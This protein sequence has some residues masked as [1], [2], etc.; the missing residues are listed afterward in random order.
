MKT[1]IGV[2]VS[3]LHGQVAKYGF[4]LPPD[5]DNP[6]DAVT[7]DKGSVL[8]EAGKAM[9]A[10]ALRARCRF[11]AEERCARRLSVPPA[12]A[13]KQDRQG[14]CH[15]CAPVMLLPLLFCTGW[16]QS[17]KDCV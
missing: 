5:V 9:S 12:G 8:R 3:L 4:A 17:L 1:F 2:H 10:R 14:V 11:L 13:C 6:F 16:C 15:L 7:L